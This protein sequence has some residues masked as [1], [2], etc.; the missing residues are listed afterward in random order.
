LTNDPKDDP[1]ARVAAAAAGAATA[2]PAADKAAGRD[3][4]DH[5]APVPAD[6]PAV[7]SEWKGLGAPVAA[8]AYRNPAGQVLRWTLRFPK[9][10]PGEEALP[11]DQWTD[12][13]IRPATLWRDKPGKP[14]RWRLAAE[15]GPRPL[16]GLERLAA[17][18]GAVVLLVE[19][20]KTADKA[21][22]RFPGFVVLTW[23]GGS[24]AVAKAEFGPLQGR[25]VVVWP[26]ADPPGR[27][28]ASA[29]ARAAVAAGALS[30]AVVDIPGYLPEDLDAWVDAQAARSTSEYDAVVRP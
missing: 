30:A 28:A 5:V 4:G 13:D 2:S 27:K 29:A 22:E 3:V 15:P 1:F 9:P 11:R 18:P 8:W 7:Q 24:N 21:A 26:D 10:M 25:H 6:A 14:L 20:E 23:P 19:G 12:K 17:H 16:Y